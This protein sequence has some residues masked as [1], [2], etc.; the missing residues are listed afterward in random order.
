MPGYKACR[1]GGI[2]RT[3]CIEGTQ[4]YGICRGTTDDTGPN[5]GVCA[6]ATREYEDCRQ[7]GMDAD[8]VCHKLRDTYV[9]CRSTG[10]I[11]NAKKKEKRFE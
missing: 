4:E 1:K 8:P 11:G 9:R 2:D 3:I 7:Q 6:E 10:S 5:K